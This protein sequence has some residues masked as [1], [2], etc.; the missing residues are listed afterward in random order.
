MSYRE[1]KNF[2]EVMRS[3]SY[4]RP[5]SVENFRTPNFELVADLLDWLLH[6]YDPNVCIPDDIS[7]ETCRVDF[8]KDVTEKV[9][10]RAGLR[11]NTKQ[12]YRADGYAVK[13]LLK[14]AKMLYDAQRSV[15]HNNQNDPLGDNSAQTKLHD[16][17]TTRSICST[18]VDA[19]IKL[20][21]L[22]GK[23]EE[24]R[25]ERE[26]AIRFLD[27]ISRNLD[28]NSEHEQVAKALNS[29]LQTHQEKLEQLKQMS[30]E[31]SQDEKNLDAKIK[32][33]K[34][35]LDRCTK[36]LSSL[37]NVRPAFMDEYEKL[38][39]E[40]ERVYE[41]YISRFRNLDYLEHELD[42]LNKEEEEKM[43]ENERALKRM[44]KRLR[45][46]E[47]RM[48]RGEG[49]DDEKKR[50]RGDN[51]VQGGMQAEDDVSDS[52][53][54]SESDP[55]SLASS[56]AVS[57]GHSSEDIVDESDESNAL[58]ESDDERPRSLGDHDF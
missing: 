5:I 19:G 56:S 38:E 32:K 36:R 22:L 49:G 39:Y 48:L 35:E 3:L 26:K 6:R 30:E 20:Y 2:C 14:L 25:G 16:L 4:H 54:T 45:E 57:V 29:M 21:D 50:D 31:L 37:T 33:K 18:I 23:E 11:L 7:T 53:V 28:N 55:I 40:L 52:D 46:E 17:K 1:C 47:W 15:D 41:T 8:I 27:G 10:L 51:R 9:Y 12:L 24:N 13:E 44:Q 42:T 58:H 34:Q 43:E